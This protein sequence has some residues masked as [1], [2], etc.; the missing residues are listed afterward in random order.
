[1]SDSYIYDDILDRLKNIEEKEQEQK[2]IHVRCCNCHQEDKVSFD[3]IE[4]GI[5]R[6]QCGGIMMVVKKPNVKMPDAKAVTVK[7]PKA[8]R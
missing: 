7:S 8:G 5:I 3:A 1:M 2:I 6:C 4:R